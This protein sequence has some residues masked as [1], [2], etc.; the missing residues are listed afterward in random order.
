MTEPISVGPPPDDRRLE[1]DVTPRSLSYG[2]P[3]DNPLADKLFDILRASW[4]FLMAA[5]FGIALVIFTWMGVVDADYFIA[6]AFSLLG[7]A[8]ALITGAKLKA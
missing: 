7:A 4:L 8:A 6:A 1:V 5:F 2:N 3:I